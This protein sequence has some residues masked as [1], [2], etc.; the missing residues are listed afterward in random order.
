MAIF[1]HILSLGII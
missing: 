1:L